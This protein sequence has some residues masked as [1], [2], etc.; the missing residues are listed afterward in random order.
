MQ[1]GIIGLP[2]VG[3]ST[4]FSALTRAEVGVSNYPFCTIKPNV[5]AVFVND[6]RL[7]IIFELL[8]GK[9]K[10]PAR[11][12]IVD[13]A[14]LV[15]GASQGEGLGNEFLSYVRSADALIHLVRCFENKEIAHIARSLD[16]IR[17]IEIIDTEL[18][19]A[20]LNL[21]EKKLEK[22]VKQIRSGEKK[23]KKEK[24]LLEKLKEALSRG[25]RIRGMSFSQEEIFRI[26]GYSLLT[27]KPVLYAANVGEKAV[28]QY[29]HP[30][31]Q[32]IRKKAELE[33]TQVVSLCASLE[34]ELGELKEKER[35]EFKK[36]LGM[37]E[38]SLE[39]LVK[40]AYKLLNLITFFTTEAELIQAWP[41]PSGIQAKEAAGK[42][43]SDMEKG[44][45]CAEVYKFSDLNEMKS[46]HGLKEKG[47]IKTEGKDYQIQDGDVVQ[48]KFRSS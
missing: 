22:V 38:S 41:V 7:D 9:R 48:F 31:I 32:S 1:V 13:L 46:I 11:I 40:A 4:L 27:L 43:H 30:F 24:E 37:K 17:D 33:E 6:G 19:L 2:N 10:I 21:V 25:E 16:P 5:G 39:M 36:D 18:I 8:G 47:L 26:K 29:G 23:I 35:E 34:K 20:D 45:I 44:F 14:G 12:K 15:K 3:K 28:L 42:I